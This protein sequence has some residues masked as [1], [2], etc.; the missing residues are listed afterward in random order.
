M[1]CFRSSSQEPRLSGVRRRLFVGHGSPLRVDSPHPWHLRRQSSC[2]PRT[3]GL[4]CPSSSPPGD[5]PLLTPGSEL[6]GMGPILGPGSRREWEETQSSPDMFGDAADE[7]LG[8]TSQL[9]LSSTP[10][11]PPSL[12][13]ASPG[14]RQDLLVTRP[15]DPEDG[16]WTVGSWLDSPSAP[17][18]SPQPPRLAGNGFLNPHNNSS[19]TYFPCF[20]PRPQW[21]GPGP[22]GHRCCPVAPGERRLARPA[23]GRL[24]RLPML[25]RRVGQVPPW[26]PPRPPRHHLPGGR[27]CHR[28]S[29]GLLHRRELPQEGPGLGR[30]F[31]LLPDLRPRDQACRG[32][33]PLD[34]GC[35]RRE[36]VNQRPPPSPQ[37][38]GPS[39]IFS[40]KLI[41]IIISGTAPRSDQG[42]PL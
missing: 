41:V 40:F 31:I 24:G 14:P 17:G 28:S 33:R 3:P 8:D 20:R 5:R 36:G 10:V 12:G 2:P 16:H 39:S 11:V 9:H 25:L 32:P 7:T 35:G 29:P 37:D 21:A 26:R 42:R 15:S 23:V 4:R 1:L 6:A 38:L 18:T 34:R 22:R 13:P 19:L 30:L 27:G